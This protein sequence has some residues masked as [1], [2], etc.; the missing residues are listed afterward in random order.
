MSR[1]RKT[2]DNEIENKNK[3]I[4]CDY[5]IVDC[6]LVAPDKL[7]FVFN[8]ATKCHYDCGVYK[9]YLNIII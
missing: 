6:F 5:L 1:I 9:R 8:N 7:G 3:Q 2:K 4:K